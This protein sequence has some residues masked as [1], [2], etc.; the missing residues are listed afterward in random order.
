[1]GRFEE[2][3]REMKQ[4]RMLDPVSRIIATDSGALLYFEQHYE[5]AY[6]ELSKVL[7]ME[8]SFSEALM[9]RGAVLL[10]QKRYAEAI[11]DLENSARID[12]GP[13]KL[14]VLGW[15]LGYAGRRPE[16]AAVL[17]RLKAMSRQR[18][19]PAWSLAVTYIGLGDADEA[20]AWLERSYAERS[21]ELRALRIDSIYDP[22]R[23]DP[24]FLDLQRRVG[25][26]Q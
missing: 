6:Q 22:L 13:R 20:F 19:V 18:R 16:A 2:A 9:F 26:V 24:R 3:D 11:A 5:A 1:M 15:G 7:E 12:S 25:L 21:G 10:Q 4:A 17:R 8:P 23:S 14:G